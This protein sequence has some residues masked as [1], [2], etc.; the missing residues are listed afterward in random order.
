[1][2]GESFC[3]ISI[4]SQKCHYAISGF[5]LS[6]L[7]NTCIHISHST[8]MAEL[9]FAAYY[10]SQIITAYCVQYVKFLFSFCIIDQ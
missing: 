8:P 1:M 9:F 5:T 2:I 7:R 6:S 4:Y 10:F 3:H